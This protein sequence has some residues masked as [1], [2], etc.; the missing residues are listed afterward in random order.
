MAPK[1]FKHLVHQLVQ[2]ANNH[3]GAYSHGDVFFESCD[4]DFGV[5]TFDPDNTSYSPENIQKDMMLRVHLAGNVSQNVHVEGGHLEVKWNGAVLYKQDLPGQECS[6]DC[7]RDLDW[8]IPGYAPSGD[9]EVHVTAKGT[10]DG[11]SGQV[12]CLNGKL[13]I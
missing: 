8:N 11:R 13:K 12:A 4:D 1:H 6:D 9:Y 10:V 5:F 2:S 3:S 7:H